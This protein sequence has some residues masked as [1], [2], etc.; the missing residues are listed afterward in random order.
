[1]VN[2]AK[3]FIDGIF[4]GVNPSSIKVNETRVIAEQTIPG[5]E[6]NVLQDMGSSPAQIELNGKIFTNSRQDKQDVLKK[7]RKKM[8]SGGT[9]SM[10]AGILNILE[11]REYLV[12]NFT[13]E[14]V[15]GKPFTYNYTL[16]LKQ[17]T[18][19]TLKVNQVYNVNKEPAEQALEAYSLIENQSTYQA[20][21][22]SFGKEATQSIMV[23]D[24]TDIVADEPAEDIGFFGGIIR[25]VRSVANTFGGW[26]S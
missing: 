1:M 9:K 7:L 13:Y 10:T 3:V 24:G 17:Y 25:G 4:L 6:G 12:E 15:G 20:S 14:E 2:R 8:M 5:R 26:F 22:L 16:S 18:K 19:T 21:W 23:E 11:T